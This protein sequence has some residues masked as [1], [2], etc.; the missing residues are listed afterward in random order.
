[1]IRRD[2]YGLISLSGKSRGLFTDLIE[3]RICKNLKLHLLI[4]DKDL[5]NLQDP[6]APASHPFYST[7]ILRR[8]FHNVLYLDS[9]TV[10]A[11]PG[12]LGQPSPYSFPEGLLSI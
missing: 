11:N 6:A 7:E 3:E 1:M 2:G 12:L 4:D 5:I 8:A 9:F 10:C